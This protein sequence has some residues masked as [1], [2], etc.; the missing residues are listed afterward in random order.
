M[1]KPSVKDLKAFLDKKKKGG[2]KFNPDIYPFWQMEAGQEAVVRILPGEGNEVYPFVERLDHKL[3]INGKIQNIPCP[4]MHGEKCPICELSQEYYREEG[5]DSENGKYYY[6]DSIHLAKALVL[7]DPLPADSESGETY[8]G[9]VVTLRLGFQLMQKINEE[10]ARLDEDE[11]LPWDLEEGMNF[12]IKAVTQGKYKKYD[13]G[14]GFARKSSSIP[15]KH[16]KNIEIIDLD[17][18]LPEAKGYDD[19]NEVLDAHLSGGDVDADSLESKKKKTKER[20]SEDSDSDAAS[21]KGALSRLMKEDEEDDDDDDNP[22]PDA[23]DDDADQS[24]DDGDGDE[25]DDDDDDLQA[26]IAKVKNRNK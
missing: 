2:K 22:L 25:E 19:I 18:L 5:D 9:R 20:L 21:S 1:A 14:S 13:V 17:T 15:K 26:I 23:D 6:R 7:E 3:T 12:T 10:C 8:E 4:S 11:P 24:S 16:L